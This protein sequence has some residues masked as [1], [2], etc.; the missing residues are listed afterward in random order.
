MPSKADIQKAKQ[1]VRQ[2]ILEQKNTYIKELLRKYEIPGGATKKD[3][4][5]RLYDAIE[6]GTIPLDGLQQWID[7][8]EG[9]GDEHVYL[10]R[11]PSAVCAEI[12]DHAEQCVKR[13]KLDHLWNAA[14]SLAFSDQRR[15]VGVSFADEE[16]RFVW[17][18]D[19]ELV[20]RA[21]EKDKPP[22]E[23]E[24]GWWYSYKAYVHSRLRSVTRI[25][26]RPGRKLAAVFLPGSSE[27]STHTDER[28]VLAKEIVKA[29]QLEACTLCEVDGAVKRIDKEIAKGKI[30]LESRHTRLKDK[31]GAGCRHREHE[32]DQLHAVDDAAQRPQCDAGPRLFRLRREVFLQIADQRNGS[33]CPRRSVR[34]FRAYPH[35]REVVAGRGMGDSRSDR[36]LHVI[37]WQDLHR[38]F[39]AAAVEILRSHL[40]RPGLFAT[41]AE[42]LASAAKIA[43]ADARELLDALPVMQRHEMTMCAANGCD[44]TGMDAKASC[45]V[46]GADLEITTV[47]RYVRTGETPRMIPWFLVVHGMNTR[48]EWQETLTWLI[49]RSYGRM[50]PVAIY[51]YGKIQPGVLFGF[52]QRQLMRKLI[53]KMKVFAEQSAEPGLDE[54]PDVIAHSFGTW[55]IANVLS[56][57]RSLKIGRLILLGSVVRPD[58]PWEELVRREQVEAILNHGATNDEWVPMAQYVIPESGP[59]GTYGFRPPVINIPA[60]CLHHSDYFEDAWLKRLFHDVWQPFLSWRTPQLNSPPV[61]PRTWKRSWW[62]VRKATWLLAVS[63]FL[64]GLLLVSAALTLG[65]RE[66]WQLM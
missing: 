38:R 56:S 9:W 7:E 52:R 15:L 33:R 43:I 61:E 17:H 66:L 35:V 30:P 48:G 46:C 8:T 65:L 6:D 18:Q 1:L 23:E 11:V 32:Q 42:E 40:S 13:A 25:V 12:A 28:A 31:D 54:R 59:G 55:L 53:A 24:D 20:E 37:D 22:A 21:K 44:L 16:L 57:D 63:I 5:E 41:T 39:P 36:A 14:P 58:F 2:V 34:R 51:K 27:P 19:T 29:F 64:I 45:S 10:Y 50:V 26:V 3:F 47:V 4:E 62:I 49:G 60:V